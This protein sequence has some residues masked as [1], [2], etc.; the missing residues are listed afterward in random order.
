MLFDPRTRLQLASSAERKL[1]GL[2]EHSALDWRESGIDFQISPENHNPPATYPP[3]DDLHAL[4]ADEAICRKF[5]QRMAGQVSVS[6]AK[7]A[8][9]TALWRFARR[10]RID[11]E[12]RATG[13]KAG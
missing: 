2:V 6:I 4:T 3:A 9:E 10:Q 11:S 1:L 5:P 12:P 13:R 7:Q 8:I